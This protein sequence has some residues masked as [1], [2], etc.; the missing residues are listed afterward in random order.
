MPLSNVL[1]SSES[2]KLGHGV[3]VRP[4]N[5]QELR[6]SYL[7]G[8]TAG[9]ILQKKATTRAI[10]GTATKDEVDFIKTAMA[11]ANKR[12]E[13][14]EKAV[15]HAR[16][17]KAATERRRASKKRAHMALTKTVDDSAAFMTEVS[18]AVTAGNFPKFAQAASEALE[19]WVG[20]TV[21]QGRKTMAFT[22]QTL[23]SPDD[24]DCNTFKLVAGDV[25]AFREQ[26]DTAALYLQCVVIT[27]RFD[28]DVV[29]GVQLFSEEDHSG[30][31]NPVLD[32]I[33][34]NAESVSHM[35]ELFSMGQSFPYYSVKTL[36][37]G[38]VQLESIEAVVDSAKKA[39][40]LLDGS[41]PAKRPKCATEDEDSSCSDTSYDPNQQS[42]DSDSE[43]ESE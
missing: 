40:G 26:T 33:M 32:R 34:V 25:G 38:L 1:T 9:H 31:A 19:H 22:I 29:V 27:K 35:D 41:P 23:T 6:A 7:Q 24:M 20:R 28:E 2:S 16:V 14:G 3:F 21:P 15:R 5:L 13:D 8:N 39:G 43:S 17:A 37:P 4:C 10:D 36:T 30:V 42:D 12:L 18:A 11:Q